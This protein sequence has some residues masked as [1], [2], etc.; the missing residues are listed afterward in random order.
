MKHSI[1]L[2]I[3]FRFFWGHPDYSGPCHPLLPH[4][5]AKLNKSDTASTTCPF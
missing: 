4:L 2:T 3:T 1:Q 5:S